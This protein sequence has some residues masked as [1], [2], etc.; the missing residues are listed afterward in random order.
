MAVH[1]LSTA[2]GYNLWAKHYELN[3]NPMTGLDGIVFEKLFPLHLIKDKTVLD[4][5]CGTGRLSRLLAAKGAQLSG[6]DISEKMLEIARKKDTKS[7]YIQILSNS[8]FPFIDKSMDFIVSNLVLE[9]VSDLAFFFKEI[10]RISKKTSLIYVS[11]MHP[12]MLLKGTQANF[13][14]PESGIEYRPKGY[15]HQIADF[16][17][18]MNKSGLLIEKMDEFLG[19]K[20]LVKHYPKAEKY[21][22][23]PML[24]TFQL[25][26]M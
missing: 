18:N 8:P 22:D 5:G 14:D 6:I 20:Y 15:P 2:E 21:L 9:H 13:K 1:E 17:K 11:A 23:W 26:L 25:K 24:V 3:G 10:S 19:T 7:S 12:A 4:I 16:V